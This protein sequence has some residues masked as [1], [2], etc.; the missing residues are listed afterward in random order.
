MKSIKIIFSLI[1]IV[2]IWSCSNSISDNEVLNNDEISN[3]KNQIDD[4]ISNENILTHEEIIKKFKYKVMVNEDIFYYT[5]DKP[6]DGSKF[7]KVELTSSR[8]YRGNNYPNLFYLIKCPPGDEEG[9]RRRK[10]LRWRINTSFR[11]TYNSYISSIGMVPEGLQICFK[12]S[13][14]SVD[15]R[16]IRFDTPLYYGIRTRYSSGSQF[17]DKNRSLVHL[18]ASHKRIGRYL[19]IFYPSDPYDLLQVIDKYRVY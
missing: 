19:D 1:L 11:P 17:V 16:V 10:E 15:C 13:S 5:N 3:E 4:D 8:M 6:T 12:T 18:V 9:D 14:S 7:E 2:T